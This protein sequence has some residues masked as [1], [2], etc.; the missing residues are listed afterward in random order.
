MNGQVVILDDE[1]TQLF[2]YGQLI[3]QPTTQT[4]IEEVSDEESEYEN[5]NFE[6]FTG[7]LKMVKNGKKIQKKNKFN[8]IRNR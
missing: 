7:M 3:P 2:E 5:G 6:N 1:E 4:S 8:N